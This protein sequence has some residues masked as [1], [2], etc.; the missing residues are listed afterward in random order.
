MVVPGISG[1]AT[2][3]MLGAYNSVITMFSNIFDIDNFKILIPF[4]IGII[5]GIFITVKIVQYLFKNHKDKTYSAILGFS[6]STIVLMFIKS[7]NS[8]YTLPNL[9]I[10]FI[11]LFIGYFISKKIN[12]LIS[13]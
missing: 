7:F 3:M 12:L 5:I 13:D 4:I 9:F 1:T 8:F 10:A 2:L 11:M 6:T